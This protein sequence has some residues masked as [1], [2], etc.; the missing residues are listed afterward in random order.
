MVGDL[1]AHLF[2][3]A[4]W[5]MDSPLE[6]VRASVATLFPERENP[7]VAVAL[8][9]S[10]RALGTLEVSRVYPVAPQRLF[11]EIEG[12]RGALRVE[13]ALAGRAKD[14]ALFLASRPGVWRPIPLD[15]ALLRR[16]DP[17]ETWGLFHFRELARRFLYAIETGTPPT[18]SLR[19]G[20]VAQAVIQAVLESAR[21]QVWQ[22]VKHV[23][24]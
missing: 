24:G 14:A 7:D 8:V 10:G 6:R 20:V 5:I 4:S 23:G 12:E 18:P 22:E 19:D 11:L 15:P 17:E 21:D 9:G 16:R 13:P 3:L 2:D 1:G